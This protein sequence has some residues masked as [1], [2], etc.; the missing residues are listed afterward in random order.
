MSSVVRALTPD[1]VAE[2]RARVYATARRLGLMKTLK[3]RADPKETPQQ[4]NE[5]GRDVNRDSDLLDEP[6]CRRK[7]PVRE[8]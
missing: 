6:G 7:R 2:L 1:E 3:A 8:E 4:L 5:L